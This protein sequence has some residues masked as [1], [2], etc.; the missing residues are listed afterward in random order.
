M[1]TSKWFPVLVSTH[2]VCH[3]IFF[4]YHI[5]EGEWE[6]SWEGIWQP[7][8]VKPSQADKLSR[9]L[10][11]T[12]FS[13]SASHR[14]MFQDIQVPSTYVRRSQ[15]SSWWERRIC[16][17]NP[18]DWVL[19]AFSIFSSKIP[20]HTSGITQVCCLLTQLS[21]ITCQCF[22]KTQNWSAFTLI[23]LSLTAILRW[24]T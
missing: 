10:N 6:S 15:I 20:I 17:K 3:L 22:K 5:Q 8:K 4:P 14:E 7:F 21:Q 16:L 19:A 24:V 11:P 9:A 1:A 13:D 12:F 18:Q 2:R 23:T